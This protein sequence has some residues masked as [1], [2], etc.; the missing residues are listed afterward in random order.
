MEYTSATFPL[1]L[2]AGI[3]DEAAATILANKALL[4]TMD[5]DEVVTPVWSSLVESGVEGIVYH[6]DVDMSCDFISGQW[7]VQSLGL[8]RAAN[9]TAW[10]L[11]DSDQIAGFVDD[12]GSMKFVTVRGAGHMVPEDKPAEALAMLNQFILN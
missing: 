6:G 12:F 11:T 1:A 7:A 3:S 4:Y 2:V 10:T 9:K 5:I 8:T